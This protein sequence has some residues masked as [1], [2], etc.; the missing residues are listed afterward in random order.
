[1]C[2]SFGIPLC[3][4]DDNFW[5]VVDRKKKSGLKTYSLLGIKRGLLVSL[6]PRNLNS[7]SLAG[8][9]LQKGI[10]F[11]LSAIVNISL[12]EYTSAFGIVMSIASEILDIDAVE[13]AA[14]SL[15]AIRKYQRDR[16]T[17]GVDRVHLYYEE[18]DWLKELVKRRKLKICLKIAHQRP[19]VNSGIGLTH[20]SLAP[21]VNGRGTASLP[22]LSQKPV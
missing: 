2:G 10:L 6:D 20:L 4:T 17:H 12:D 16:S 5:K 13:S 18:G 7:G 11:R 1:L 3:S 9:I 15:R 19:I 14:L 21:L 22:R 8:V